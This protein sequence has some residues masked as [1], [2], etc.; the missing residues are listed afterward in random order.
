MISCKRQPQNHCHV[1][2][3]TP[4]SSWFSSLIKFKITLC[5]KLFT[6][7]LAIF[8]ELKFSTLIPKQDCN[9][10]TLFLWF[11]SPGPGPASS[12]SD[13]QWSCSCLLFAWMFK[14]LAGMF[15]TWVYIYNHSQNGMK[16]G[17][18]PSEPILGKIEEL[19]MITIYL[20]K[21]RPIF[22]W[23]VDQ[24]IGL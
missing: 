14:K 1:T 9:F 18:L 13:K 7:C 6:L 20:I 21:K 3:L 11:G 4:K 22:L 5:C 12:Q 19:R 15:Q 23:Y 8:L 16:K 24:A 10:E 17:P 2:S